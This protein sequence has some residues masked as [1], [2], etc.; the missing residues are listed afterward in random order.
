MAAIQ[1]INTETNERGTM[2]A[3]RLAAVGEPWRALTADELLELRKPAHK[4]TGTVAAAPQPTGS[5]AT[6]DPAE[7]PAGNASRD[8]WA[9]YAAT[10][11]ANVT[12]EMTR[13]DIRAEVDRVAPAT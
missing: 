5:T 8:A 13:D 2:T 9:E 7:R 4:R 11:G 3:K 1:V 12:D 10:V 6:T